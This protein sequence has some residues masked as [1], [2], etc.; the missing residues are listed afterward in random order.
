MT[1]ETGLIKLEL[2]G[3]EEASGGYFAAGEKDLL[4]LFVFVLN[5]GK[6]LSMS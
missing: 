5:K 1:N 3:D 4:G 6:V 2:W